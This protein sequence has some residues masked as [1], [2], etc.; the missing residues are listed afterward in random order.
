M[1]EQVTAP[2]PF[3]TGDIFMA[4]TDLDDSNIDFRNLKGN[5]RILHFDANFHR[6]AEL[7]T[8]HE[9]L[10]VN[11]AVDP[12]SGILYTVDPTGRHVV[13][14]A[15][16]GTR[17]PEIDWLPNRPLSAMMF[18]GDGR[19]YVGVHSFRGA[20][21]DDQFGASKF[22]AF[23]TA[24]QAVEALDME[25]DGGHVGWLGVNYIAL[26]AD[27]KTLYSAAEGG[28]RILRYDLETRQ[29]LADYLVYDTE[30]ADR[31]FGF[32]FLA[33]GGLALVTGNSLVLRN[34]DGTERLRK[35]LG[36]KGWTRVIL[37]RDGETLFVINFLEG[38]LQRR[39]IADG[40]VLFEYDL[41]LKCSMCGLVE[42]VLP[43]T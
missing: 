8:G 43:Q 3:E 29:H 5:G 27:G 7:W 35:V 22:F 6:K 9:G 33:D 38:R 24:D 25:V 23:N 19:G 4:A 31:T 15:P 36:E 37:A 12:S 30:N 10:T 1:S 32:G 41:G 28:H 42:Y 39:K 16:D 11:L 17:L 21:P 40:S 2:V 26:A 13:P 18:L 20:V 34:A 14:F